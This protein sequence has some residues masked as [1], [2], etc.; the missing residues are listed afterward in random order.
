MPPTGGGVGAATPKFQLLAVEVRIVNS[1]SSPTAARLETQGSGTAVLEPGQFST[2]TPFLNSWMVF[3][4]SPGTI[5]WSMRNTST[6]G[7]VAESPVMSVVVT[8]TS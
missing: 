2:W 7:F 4:V 1:K 3:S 5:D 6:N 8:I